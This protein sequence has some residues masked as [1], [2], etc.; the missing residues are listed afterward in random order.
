MAAA[1]GPLDWLGKHKDGIEAIGHIGSLLGLFLVVAGLYLTWRTLRQ[2]IRLARETE[3]AATRAYARQKFEDYLREAY[4]NPQFL[5]DYWQRED[6]R[7]DQRERYRW[8]VKLT[9]WACEQVLKG[10]P[11]DPEWPRVVHEHVSYHAAYLC[12][13]QFNELLTYELPV[14]LVIKEVCADHHHAAGDGASAL[15]Q[16]SRAS[17]LPSTIEA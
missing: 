15:E 8:F 7:P 13:A 1:Q 4:A 16:A 12:S 14:Q 17:D 9:L 10:Y 6:L 11:D 3:L 2:Q 5:L